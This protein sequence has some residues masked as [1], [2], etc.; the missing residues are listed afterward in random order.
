MIVL[1][2]S[3]A[4]SSSE[5]VLEELEAGSGLEAADSDLLEDFSELET[6]CH[7]ASS[8]AVELPGRLFAALLESDTTEPDDES[9]LLE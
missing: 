8:D 7:P 1:L 9:E 2:W 3:L 4:G 5:G 6:L